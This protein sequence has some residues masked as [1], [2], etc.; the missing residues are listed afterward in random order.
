MEL[1][2]GWHPAPD[3]PGYLRYWDGSDWTNRYALMERTVPEPAHDPA[4][5]APEASQQEAERP[6]DVTDQD[7]PERPPAPAESSKRVGLEILVATSIALVLLISGILLTRN[8]NESHSESDKAGGVDLPDGREVDG[9]WV[10]WKGFFEE[11]PY[12]DGMSLNLTNISEEEKISAQTLTFYSASGEALLEVD[13]NTPRLAWEPVKPGDSI[14]LVCYK[15]DT[16]FVPEKV[17]TDYDYLG[18]RDSL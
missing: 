15:D 11:T 1:T 18:L 13:C 12:R 5:Y 3:R 16:D 17:P 9:W 14:F 2:Q 4:D 6:V 8:D 7:R 10:S